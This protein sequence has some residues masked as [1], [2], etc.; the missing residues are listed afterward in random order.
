MRRIEDGV[1]SRRWL[2]GDGSGAG[3]GFLPGDGL[4]RAAGGLLE[5]VVFN[6][7]YGTR[8]GKSAGFGV[9]GCALPWMTVVMGCGHG[10]AGWSIRACAAREPASVVTVTP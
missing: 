9:G 7:G 6:R 8:D 5:N 3:H 4:A 1:E 2:G 10:T